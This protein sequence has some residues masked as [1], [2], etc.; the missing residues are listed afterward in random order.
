VGGEAIPRGVVRALAQDRAGFLW[1]ATGD[2]VL[3]YDGHRFRPAE[4]PVEK[5][6]AR[7]GA[8]APRRHLGWVRTLLATRDGRLWMGTAVD[9]LVAHD[10]ASDALIDAKDP[11]LGSAPS[12]TITALAEDSDGSVW[13]G[14]VGAGLQHYQPASGRHRHF[15]AAGGS[16]PD[17]R[18]RALLRARDGTLWVGHARGLARRLPGATAEAPPRFEALPALGG[19]QVQALAE[20]RDG[21]LWAGTQQGGLFL[22]DPASGQA[23]ALAAPAQPGDGRP[24]AVTALAEDAEGV[25]WVGRSSGIHLHDARSGRALRAL[26]HD[27]A[28]PEGLAGHEVATLLH[29]ADGAVWVGGPG[30][31]LQRHEPGQG[32]ISVHAP[33]TGGMPAAAAER[34]ADLRGLLQ[35]SDGTLWA[36]DHE[37]RLLLMDAGLA[38]QRTLPAFEAAGQP[39][40][41]RALLEAEQGRVWLGAEGQLLLVDRQGRLLRRLP[42]AGGITHQMQRSADGSLWVGSHD[43][44]YRLAPGASEVQR[45]PLADGQV[46]EGDV[47]DTVAAPDGSLWVASVKGLF[48]IGPGQAVLQPVPAASAEAALASPVVIGL[49]LDRQQ[50]L[51]VDT[52]GAGLHRLLAWDGRQ[53]RFDRVS[54]RHGLQRRPFG[55]SLQA[56]GEGRIWTHLHVHDPE[57]DTLHTLTAAERVGFGTGWL[58]A[59]AQA[60]DGRLFFGGSRGLLV[61]QPELFRAPVRKAPLRLTELR[62]NGQPQPLPHPPAPLKLTRE[63]RSLALQFAAL[64]YADPTRHRYAYRL[65]GHDADWVPT[66]PDMRMASY[67]NLEPGRYTLRVR[68]APRDGPWRDDELALPLQVLPAW[69]QRAEFKLLAMLLGLS[70]LWALLHWRTRRLRAQRRLLEAAVAAR[71]AELEATRAE[72]EDRVQARTRELAEA[73]AA[74]EAANRAKTAFLQNVSHEMRTPL[75]AILGLTYLAHA[76]AGPGNQQRRLDQ[77]TLAAKQLLALINEVLERARLE[78]GSSAPAIEL[79]RTPVLPEG[80]PLPQFGGERVL[81]AEDEPVNQLVA[82]GVLERA[83]LVVDVAENGA[84][85]LQ[86][87]ARQPYALVLMDLQMPELDGLAATRALRATE[88]GRE[89]PIVALSAFAF[90]EDRRRCLE[91]GMND[92]LSKP[93][94]PAELLHTVRRWLRQPTGQ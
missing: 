71:T 27:R 86:L 2:G 44:L 79:P 19:A 22:L 36:A 11:A 59:R 28:R 73:S 6:A 87:A 92:H 75:N 50:R 81:L 94:N 40:R 74:A 54:Q 1:V 85:A 90:D 24:G 29:D 57:A 46:L 76:E 80:T 26:R 66:E 93:V 84:Q 35:H 12:P 8:E 89:L 37:G 16:L 58:R 69:W 21:R 25:M 31:G 41:I 7:G 62:I 68:S 23:T 32:A 49:L 33:R 10:P 30:I 55:A 5:P 17:D 82:V 42:H 15:R 20:A 63:Q 9:G 88:A 91:A 14:T 4:R 56:D 43:G 34:G 3:R 18:V 67:S 72:L 65:E 53:A 70:S 13:A 45:V 83:G 48:R 61:V 78:A 51:W 64:D 52:A 60:P 38:L 77:V 39:L 47:Y